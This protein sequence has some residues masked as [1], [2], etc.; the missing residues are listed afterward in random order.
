MRDLIDE[1]GQDL[2]K[3]GYRCKDEGQFGLKVCSMIVDTKEKSE[4]FGFEEGEYIILNCEELPYGEENCLVYV[5]KHIQ[6][7]I[8]TLLRKSSVNNKA[9]F[10]VVGLGNPNILADSLGIKVLEQI[11]IK[12]YKNSTNVFKF[13]PN[14]FTNTGINAYEVV[15][16]L[17]VW[18]DIDCVIVIDSLATSSID[19]L[20]CSIQLNTAGITPGSAL[21]NFGKEIS[22]NT[23]GVPC[24][25][26]G[27]PLMFFGDELG[28]GDL[29]LTP[30]DI[31]QNVED[32]ALVIGNAISETILK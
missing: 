1:C 24:I 12:T 16:M 15:N 23:L 14:I 18:L 30:K 28:R 5:S 17:S 4:E 11:R 26:I 6:K 3:L 10:L 8:K 27:V 29:L 22:R 9:K 21:N 32:V 2:S 20:G 13:A 7:V 25:S 19:R 31:H